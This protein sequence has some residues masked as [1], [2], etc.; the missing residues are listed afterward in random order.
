MEYFKWRRS[1]DML[2]SCD[3]ESRS[4]GDVLRSESITEVQVRSLLEN[5]AETSG[6]YS[7][8]FCS[9]SCS[10]TETVIFT[11]A[12]HQGDDGGEWPVGVKSDFF[13][14]V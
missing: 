3:D 12:T 11:R 1:V 5:L 8:G 4:W 14:R 7:A 2:R 10:S 13:S 9:S 6:F